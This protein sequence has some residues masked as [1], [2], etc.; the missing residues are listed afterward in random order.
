MK[1][2]AHV[3]IMNVFYLCIL[4]NQSCGRLFWE[5]NSVEPAYTKDIEQWYLSAT[6]DGNKYKIKELNILCY[7]KINGQ[8]ATINTCLMMIKI[9][10][11]LSAK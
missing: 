7:N 4:R 10:I 11:N 6:V 2:W 8:K 3:F 1:H 5:G 9:Y